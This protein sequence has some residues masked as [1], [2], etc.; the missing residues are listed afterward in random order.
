MTETNQNE[1]NQLKSSLKSGSKK[2]HSRL[3]EEMAFLYRM[4]QAFSSSL[5]LG[6]VLS[7][8]LEEVCELLN[9]AASSIW[10]I[11][12][13][14]EELVCRHVSNQQVWDTL[15][16]WRLKP[17]KGIVGWVAEHGQSAVVHD[18]RIDSRYYGQIDKRTGF[19]MRSLLNIPLK[20]KESTIG[21]LQVVD[22]T[23][24]RFKNVDLSLIESLGA[25]ASIAIENARLY[26]QA[27]MEIQE[28]QRAEG[29]L[30]EKTLY[31]NHILSSSTKMAIVAT[32]LDFRIK[33]FNTAAENL[34]DMPSDHAIG[35]L[36]PEISYFK[37]TGNTRFNH[38]VVAIREKGEYLDS[39]RYKTPDGWQYIES[40]FSG[41]WGGDNE[42]L[43]FVLMAQDITE[44]IRN[45]NALLESEHRYRS[46]FENAAVPMWELD[47]SRLKSHIEVR[48]WTTIENDYSSIVWPKM[49]RIIDANQAT[50]ELYGARSKNLLINYFANSYDRLILKDM[51]P[52]IKAIR[53]GNTRCQFDCQVENMSGNLL[54]V[55]VKLTVVPDFEDTWTKVMLSIVDI[56]SLKRA[57]EILKASKNMAEEANDAKSAFV[58]TLS[59]ELRNFLTG[60]L[61]P[62]QNL[63]E[64]PN[65]SDEQRGTLDLINDSSEH[66]MN[67][68]SNLL[69]ISR[70]EAQKM[71]LQPAPFDLIRRLHHLANV[72]SYQAGKK[73]LQFEMNLDP[74]L[75]AQVIADE[76]RLHQILLNLL[77]NAIKYTEKGSITL[78]VT[79]LSGDIK[80][81]GIL[82]RFMV[83][84]TG[85]GIPTADI[86]R[87]FSL[88]VR[89]KNERFK[90]MG[91]GLGLTISSK[92]VELMGSKLNVTSQPGKG[93]T[94]WFDLNVKIHHE[95]I[96]KKSALPKRIIGYSG[97]RK[98]ILIVDDLPETRVFMNLILVNLGFTVYEAEDGPRA[99]EMAK[100]HLPDLIFMDLMMP[101]LSGFETTRILRQMPEFEKTIILA[102][103][104]TVNESTKQESLK[105][106][107]DDFMAKPFT[108]Q[109]MFN[110]IHKYLKLNWVYADE[111]PD[112]KS[113]DT[114][115]VEVPP[116]EILEKLYRLAMQ[117]DLS[118]L[119]RMVKRDIET[120]PA[121]QIFGAQIQILADEFQIEQIQKLLNQNIHQVQIR[122]AVK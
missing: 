48:R 93:S 24:N 71:E 25:S 10:L 18:S 55:I 50:M 114:S 35:Q 49:V 45:Q 92:L 36:L 40:R 44:Q 39:S 51:N 112:Q 12:P 66:L 30:L 54:E 9:V 73:N 95:R 97:D 22:T 79:R 63:R 21:V 68:T 117:G 94:F 8:V 29:S 11:D 20:V 14:T 31:L 122:N 19:E 110:N 96:S 88:F 43:G 46:L 5:E 81:D 111:F 64:D 57:E 76:Q 84:D 120:N 27:Q 65:L 102:V 91:L 105:A 1:K 42:L 70:I 75:P 33:Y 77:G 4:T 118:E 17:G 116:L 61:G 85:I 80:P 37:Q 52:I 78:L 26:E 106:G 60:I 86:E 15:I 100:K 113:I 103:T 101:Y 83:K 87:I 104:A 53:E 34:F 62:A 59:H 98:T 3:G 99:I 2:S 67:M 121:Y 108:S 16:G 28:R 41:I 7:R 13:T 82:L 72:A 119:D 69:D 58:R 115:L 6:A 107:F 32:D 38:A 47:L 23:V 56:T 74:D 89:V 109:T 90:S